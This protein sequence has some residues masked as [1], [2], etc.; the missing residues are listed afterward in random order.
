MSPYDG[1]LQSLRITDTDPVTST[2]NSSNLLANI[3]FG[4]SGCQSVPA[5]TVEECCAA[6]GAYPACRY[7]SF[8]GSRCGLY[9]T[10]AEPTPAKGTLSGACVKSSPAP[11]FRCNADDICLAVTDGLDLDGE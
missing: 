5:A 8:S 2:C 11:Q 10:D 7:F 4:Q 9:P 3:K 6:C 1:L